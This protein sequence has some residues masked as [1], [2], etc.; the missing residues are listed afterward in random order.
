MSAA[1]DALRPLVGETALD[2]EYSDERLDE[3]LLEYVSQNRAAAA[4]WRE[5]AATYSDLVDVSESGSSR[6]MSDLLKNAL[7]MAEQY[8]ALAAAEVVVVPR[9]TRTRAIVRP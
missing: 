8:D 4:I 5:K 7:A 3:L 2:S 1:T 6:K 9:G